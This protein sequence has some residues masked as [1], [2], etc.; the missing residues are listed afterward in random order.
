MN[1]RRAKIN[2]AELCILKKQASLDYMLSKRYLTK[3]EKFRTQ[4]KILLTL[5]PTHDNLGDHAIAYAGKKFLKENF[6]DYEILEVNIRDIYLYAKAIRD[7]M[8]PNDLVFIIGG[9][10]MGDLYR[11][12]EWTRRFIIKTFHDFKIINLPA[13]VHFTNTKYGKSELRISKKVYNSHPNL[14]ILARDESSW[15]FMKKHFNNCKIIKH[16]DI[17]L[18]LNEKDKSAKERSGILLCLRKDKE[19]YLKENGRELIE[20]TLIENYG[21]LEKFS[22]TIGYRVNE[23]TRENELTALWNKLR[24]AEVVVTD[25]LHGMIFCAITETPCVVLRSFDHKVME[26][27]SWLEDLNYMKLITEPN[28]T[29]ILNAINSLKIVREKNDHSLRHDYF[30]SLNQQLLSN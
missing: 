26:G 14:T 20:K 11:N 6:S 24:G 4:K 29:S 17:V 2:L 1:L 30:S 9:G 15:K 23:K 27:Y 25:R 18:Y 19:S 16:P 3:F 8:N 13:T 21:E 10:N 12:E 7:V 5:I 22:T 28:E